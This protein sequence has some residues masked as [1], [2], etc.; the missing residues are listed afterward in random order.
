[1]SI[2]KITEDEVRALWVQRLSDTPNR[3][4]QFGTA[5]LSAG[6]MKAAYD[7][8][9]L[10]L[11]ECFNELVDAVLT[12]RLAELIPAAEGRSLAA[13]LRDVTSGELADYLTADGVRS[14][15]EVA[16][17]LDTH[18]HDAR[19]ARLGPDGR[20]AAEHLPA[21]HESSFAAAEAERILAEK[22]REEAEAER[23]EAL[24]VLRIALES[25]SS[26][27]AERDR[28]ESER[29]VRLAAA[30]ETL[31][32][33]AAL[34]EETAIRVGAIGCE[35]KNLAAAAEGATHSFV[36]DDTFAYKKRT[37]KGALPYAS[38]LRLGGPE[39]GSVA[40]VK[41]IASYGMSLLP[42]PYPSLPTEGLPEGFSVTPQE[43]GSLIFN[44]Y[45]DRNISL[46]LY[47]EYDNLYLPP[48][49]I[50]ADPI[51]EDGL[52][53]FVRTGS[54]GTV[55]RKESFTPSVND[56][57]FGR[58]YVYIYIE[59]GHTFDNLRVCPSITRGAVKRKG[60]LWRPPVRLEIPEEIRALPGYGRG[61]NILDLEEGCYRRCYDTLGHPIPEERYPLSEE[62]LSSA[63]IPAQ[64]DGE[65]VFENER[66]V[67]VASTLAFGIR[68]V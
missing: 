32:H 35:V 1:M 43:D 59:A 9:P 6:E 11:V 51:A 62:F 50:Y 68:L 3:H 8:L 29:E 16:A 54:S 47:R 4:G 24:A 46:S 23:E 42:Y 28:R 41:A 26:A 30:E 40:P 19:Y 25:L 61:G 64:E 7:A 2:R 38:L 18:S 66:G 15:R 52:T 65:I 56:E 37:P 53:L 17:L 31:S 12:G 20:L 34:S 27:E 10:R 55:W 63:F 33:A 39:D 14:L 13:F 21:G 57:Y 60:V 58:Y 22:R 49:P 45:S 5:G 44:G 48:E 36:E 67:A